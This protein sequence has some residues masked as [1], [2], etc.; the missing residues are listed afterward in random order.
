MIKNITQSEINALRCY[1]G[2]VDGNTEFFPSP[3]AYLVINSLFFPGIVSESARASEKKHLPSEVLK[4]ADILQKF[5]SCL[6]SLFRKS[7][8]GNIITSYRVERFSDYM[9][10]KECGKTVSF[11]STSLNGFLGRYSDRNGIALMKFTISKGTPCVNVAEI[12]PHYMKSDEAEI[13]LPPSLEVSINEIPLTP[14]QLDITDFS[15]NSPLVSCNVIT[16]EKFSAPCFDFSQDGLIAGQ[17]VLES[18]NKGVS[19]KSEDIRKY[20][21]MKE[22]IFGLR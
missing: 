13:L 22:K 14:E 21:N 5:F 4:N 1:T 2:D 15:G 10:C 12:L 8:A 3:D 7:S 16:S 9:F 6:F 19:P 18:L 17:R 20:S 11:T